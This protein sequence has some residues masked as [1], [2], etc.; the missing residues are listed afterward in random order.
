MR[1]T[2]FDSTEFLSCR[3]IDFLFVVA[4]AGSDGDGDEEEL[5]FALKCRLKTIFRRK[6]TRV[7]IETAN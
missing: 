7:E 2:P 1:S 5:S 6:K 4:F 3:F